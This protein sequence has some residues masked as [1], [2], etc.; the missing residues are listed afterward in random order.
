[1]TVNKGYE[2]KIGGRKRVVT[3]FFINISVCFQCGSIEAQMKAGEGK[4]CAS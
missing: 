1:M 3:E 2:K 4:I